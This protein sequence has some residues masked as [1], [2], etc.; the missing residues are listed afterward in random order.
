MS[1]VLQLSDTHLSRIPH[2]DVNGRDPDERLTT[3]LAAWGALGQRPDL[4]V[5]T[6]DNS[7]DGSLEACRRLAD[8]VGELGAPVL[9]V[10]GNH[11]DP[12]A[13]A[14]AFGT[15]GPG[16]VVDLGVW[17]VVGFDT[18]RPQ[19]VHG[20]LDVP[21]ALEVLDRLDRRPV[22]VVLHHPPI[23]RSTNP[24]FQLDGSAELLAG[25]AERPHVKVVATGHLHDAFDLEGP[26]G[27]GLLGCPSTL[28]AIAHR[29]EAMEL[30]ADAP[31]GAR[32]L[33]LDDDGSWSSTV[34]VA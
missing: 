5:V 12:A 8:A 6:G 15:L 14:S 29:G 4:I 32:I 9:A 17:N 24:W 19:Q 23:S 31:T 13:V 28:L 10:P 18:S 16:T 25:L 21:A 2:G 3:V 20:T 27:V 34:L 22:L 1:V 11:D 7:D 33:Q 26:G 30:G